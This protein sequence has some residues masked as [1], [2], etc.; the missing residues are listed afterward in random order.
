MSL[1]GFGSSLSALTMT[2]GNQGGYVGFHIDRRRL[3][4]IEAS[5]PRFT[6]F[7]LQYMSSFW[8]RRAA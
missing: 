6:S 8:V 2:L 1:A 3:G 7:D 4:S 5:T